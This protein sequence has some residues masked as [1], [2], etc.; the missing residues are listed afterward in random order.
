MTL[1]TFRGDGPPEW[2]PLESILGLEECDAF[3]YMGWLEFDGRRLHHYK[4]QISRRYLLVNDALE[5]YRYAGGSV[6]VPR[7]RKD[8]IRYVLEE[9]GQR[10]RDIRTPLDVRRMSGQY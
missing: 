3:M 7:A 1:E 10:G 5:T 2:R 6:Y 8:A 9:P 4:H